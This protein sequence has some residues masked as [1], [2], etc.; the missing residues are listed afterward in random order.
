MYD[1]G[2]INRI[3]DITIFYIDDKI[4][5]GVGVKLLKHIGDSVNVGETLALIYYKPK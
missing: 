5:Y 2:I 3:M 4:D 1:L